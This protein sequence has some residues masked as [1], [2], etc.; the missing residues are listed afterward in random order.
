MVL[1]NR[2]WDIYLGFIETWRS[3]ITLFLAII[4]M[5]MLI[6]LP[7]TFTTATGEGDHTRL[8]T[9]RTEISN[10]LPGQA[11]FTTVEVSDTDFDGQDEIY[12]GGSGSGSPRTQGIRAYEYDTTVG[13]WNE[14]GYGLARKDSGKYYGAL[15]LGDV[16]NDGNIDLVAPLLTKWYGG[17]KKGIEIYSGDGMGGFSLEF[18]I[19]T[20]E[21]SN[22]ADVKDLDGDGNLDIAVS[23]EFAL[24]VWF[25]SGALDDWIEKS[26][27]RAGN[28]ITGLDAGDLN[29]DGLLDL[30][31]CPYFGSTKVRMYIQSSGRIWEEI[32]FREV[33]NEAFGIKIA[34]LDG[35]EKSDVVYGTRNNGIKAWLGNG[36]GSQGGFDFQWNDGSAGLHD[37]GGQWQQ[38]EVQDITGDGKPE[39]IAAN[40]GGDKAYLYLNDYPNGWS[41]I[42]RGDS[43]L[44]VPILKE[45]TLTIGGEPY[46]ANFGDWDGDGQ[47]DLAAG[48]WGTGVKAWLI[49]D[50]ATNQTDQSNYPEGGVTPPKI[51]GYDDYFYLTIFLLLGIGIFGFTVIA[52]RIGLFGAKRNT[53][54]S[55]DGAD[56]RDEIW[57]LIRGNIL[58]IT[59]IIFLIIFQIL[60]IVL[61]L[62][63]GLDSNIFSFW[64]PPEILGIILYSFF[65]FVA[66]LI[67]FDIGRTYS[68]KGITDLEMMNYEENKIHETISLSRKFLLLV[69]IVIY[70]SIVILFGLIINLFYNR[71]GLEYI[72]L[73]YIGLIP[74]SMFFFNCSNNI[75]QLRTE[76]QRTVQIITL[77]TSF[78]MVLITIIVSISVLSSESGIK[79]LIL[80]YPIV[81]SAFIF[82][83][84]ILNIATLKSILTSHDS[85][86]PNI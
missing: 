79:N 80:F 68:R 57:N 36:G 83:W 64:N 24:R 44:E 42:F 59:G 30:V 50:N 58:I 3:K 86:K 70:I 33:R 22:E 27:P 56:E 14:Y 41:W 73:I 77:I 11:S 19:E 62:T 81:L 78:L 40:N 76:K 18:T 84:T 25:G 5:L 12:L 1:E 71:S 35:D 20:G 52:T 9:G 21:S 23:T 66:F 49:N 74:L 60:G 37:S 48:S 29:D 4:F 85:P 15:S 34:D 54:V 31:G 43:D 53:T 39:L 51:W 47:L 72:I 65:G 82:T 13:E 10:G 45:E 46:G 61:S 55:I 16:N 17:N 7:Y 2:N 69:N 8:I 32:S 26:P 38:L 67:F 63:N 28:E 6:A 75:I